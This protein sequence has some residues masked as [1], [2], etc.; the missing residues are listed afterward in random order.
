VDDGEP[1]PNLGSWYGGAGEAADHHH[2]ARPATRRD[3]DLV[4][5]L[6][7]WIGG[8]EVVPLHRRVVDINGG[9][10]GTPRLSH[11]LPLATHHHG[12]MGAW[13]GEGNVTDRDAARRWR[14]REGSGVHRG[15][16]E[17][18]R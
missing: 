8:H 5:R 13:C 12:D 17:R 4:N 7:H 9:N 6:R 10:L 2:S 3:D 14:E 15:G 18:R 16:E 11:Q 1:H